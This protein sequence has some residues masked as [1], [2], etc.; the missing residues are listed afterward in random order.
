MYVSNLL[1]SQRSL[2]LKASRNFA[3]TICI[4]A[5]TRSHD[6][7]GARLMRK[8]KELS[9]DQVTFVGIGGEEMQQ[10][11][12]QKNYA[13]VNNFPDKPIV[14]YKNFLHKHIVQVFHPVMFNTYAAN[15][16]VLRQLDKSN[17]WEEMIETKPQ[18][19]LTVGN[20][21]FMRAAFQELGSRYYNNDVLKPPM[22]HYDNLIINQRVEFQDFCDYWLY[23]LP[24]DPINWGYYKFPST[25]VGNYAAGD[26]IR[27]LYSQSAHAKHL[28]DKETILIS[29]EY[30]SSILDSLLEEE[31]ARFR[32]KNNLDE[33][34]TVFYGLPGNTEAEI[35]W[36]VPLIHGTVSAFLKKYS[37]YDAS[38]FAVVVTSYPQHEH[39]IE[40]EISKKSWPCKLIV[41]KTPEE[42]YSA[43][44]GS[45]MGVVAN[46]DA[47][48]E[49]AAYHLP[50]VI[51]SKLSFF[52]A[53]VSLLYNSFNNPLNIAINGEAYPE[54]LGQVFPEK[55]TEY[56]SEWFEKPS[57]KYDIVQR[58]ENIV[59]KLLPEVPGVEEI[60]ESIDTKALSNVAVPFNKYY[61]P[62]YLGAK[63]IL[64]AT[65]AYEASNANHL[66][67]FEID[68]AREQMLKSFV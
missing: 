49:C 45:D 16:K 46:G 65:S 34:A 68:K 53:Y 40:S 20:A 6:V 28:L 54:C 56:W 41:A 15:R 18:A 25:Y 30:N 31:R 59:V 1:A 27:Y 22:I 52:E 29:K 7:A 11:G 39:L 38:N 61:M 3:T 64:E 33:G 26:A 4:M 8:I 44:A 10:E 42:K 55:I 66:K 35:K 24:K 67:R 17:F 60:E 63:K 9:K 36:A 21:A 2:T 12:L 37:Q 43:L 48:A 57:R 14:P 19:F 13:D 51:I 47:A 23:S 32:Q 50:A 58:F 62:D 5:G